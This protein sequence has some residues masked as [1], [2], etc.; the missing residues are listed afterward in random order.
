LDFLAYGLLD[1]RIVTRASSLQRVFVRAR[2]STGHDARLWRTLL[3]VAT[4]RS[5]GEALPLL[6]AET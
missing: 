2:R 5:V 4:G 3:R 6:F 1:V